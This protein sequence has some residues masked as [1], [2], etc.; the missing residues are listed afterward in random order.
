VDLL[1]VNLIDE[2]TVDN[3]LGDQCERRL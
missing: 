1:Y 3:W 2:S